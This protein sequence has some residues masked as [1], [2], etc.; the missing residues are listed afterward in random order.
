MLLRLLKK[1]LEKNIFCDFIEVSK[2][3]PKLEKDNFRQDKR[4]QRLKQFYTILKKFMV[5]VSK[6]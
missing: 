3:K 4:F 5:R 2:E 1:D 6:K